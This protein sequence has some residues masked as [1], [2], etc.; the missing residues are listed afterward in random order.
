MGGGGGTPSFAMLLIIENKRFKMC[1]IFVENLHFTQGFL[2]VPCYNNDVFKGCW[3]CNNHL[4][5]KGLK[6]SRE[7]KTA[8]DNE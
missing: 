1:F 6:I 3:Q 8:N 2:G 4:Q 5:T 7:S